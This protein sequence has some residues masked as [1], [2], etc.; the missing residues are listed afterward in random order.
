MRQTAQER[1]YS[2][3]K[4]HTKRVW[5]DYDERMLWLKDIENEITQ[6]RKDSKNK[7]SSSMEFQKKASISEIKK[8]PSPVSWKERIRIMKQES[9]LKI[10]RS[11]SNLSSASNKDA[12]SDFGNRNV[13]LT[14]NQMHKKK[15]NSISK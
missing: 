3:V 2:P 12:I 10:E 6:S 13:D 8:A 1:L 15:S 5:G 4:K 9:M 7:V 14:S 11:T